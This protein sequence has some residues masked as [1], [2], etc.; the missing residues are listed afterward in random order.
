MEIA[1]KV[2][3]LLTK[4]EGGMAGDQNPPSSLTRSLFGKYQHWTKL[5][6]DADERTRSR[7]ERTWIDLGD[8]GS[9]SSVEALLRGGSISLAIPDEAALLFQQ[10]HSRHIRLPAPIVAMPSL[11]LRHLA[12]PA[13]LWPLLLSA[14][15]GLPSSRPV[16]SRAAFTHLGCF[17]DVPQRA[18]TADFKGDDDMTVEMCAEYCTPYQYFGV[19]YG[20]ECYCGNDRAADSV[21][22]SDADCSFACA[23]DT[24][25]TCGAGMRLNV[26]TNNAYSTSK[27]ADTAPPGTPY[28]G[29]FVDAAARV[30][31]ERVISADDVTPAKWARIRCILTKLLW[32]GRIYKYGL[33]NGIGVACSGASLVQ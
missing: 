15:A 20:R 9:R 12:G 31:P 3:D 24:S 10:S 26:Y 16:S 4:R 19:E 11:S 23:G 30:L 2:S 8:A 28:F 29:C 13:L 17:I 33:I 18:L 7:H 32:Y 27:P 1:S 21:A 14:V 5:Q 22:A 25:E 6:R